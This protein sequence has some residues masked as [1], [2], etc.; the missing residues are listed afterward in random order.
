MH[1]FHEAHCNFM[2]HELVLILTFGVLVSVFGFA[3][4]DSV[5]AQNETASNMT[6]EANMTNATGGNMTGGNATTSDTGS[7]NAKTELEAG[8]K[9][10]Q[11]GDVSAAKSHLMV[12]QDSM[13]GSPPDA[14][15]HFEE[16]MKALDS[17]DNNAAIMH[18]NVANDALG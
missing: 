12:A 17:G 3:T 11:G 2:R 8:I 7:T 10:L 15:R 9:A 4:W 14:I 18:L 13:I 5:F 16:G 1:L 6:S